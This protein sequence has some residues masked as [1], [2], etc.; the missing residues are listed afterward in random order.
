M[1]SAKRVLYTL[2]NF[3]AAMNEVKCRELTG[4]ILE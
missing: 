4:E 3:L 2:V 1:A